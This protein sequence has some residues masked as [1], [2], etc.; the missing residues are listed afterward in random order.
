MSPSHLGIS[1]SRMQWSRNVFQVRLADLAMILVRVV[2]PMRQDQ[3]RIDRAPSAASNHCLIAS[4]CCGKEAI[5]KRHDLDL[6]T[7][8]PGEKI[9]WRMSW[10][11][12]RVRRRRSTRTNA[13]RAGCR[14]PSGSSSVAPAPISMSSECAPRQS[15]DRRSPGLASWQRPHHAA[16]AAAR[17]LHA[18][19]HLAALH[20]V[21]EDLT[22]AQRVHRAPE[23]FVLVG[24]E[25]AA[26]DQAVERLEHEFLAFL[27]EVEDLLAEDE[28]SRR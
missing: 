16:L 27:D 24:H 13:R 20:H 3:V 14:A 9:R 15:S 28:D 26:L 6:R 10:P 19:R 7:R 5:A 22:V 2:A 1:Y 21:F 8:G 17:R 18:P 12:R 23:P 11:H 4:P 25:V